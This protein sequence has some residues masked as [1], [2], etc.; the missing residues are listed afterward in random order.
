M[1]TNGTI[2]RAPQENGAAPGRVHPKFGLE[3]AALRVLE[4]NRVLRHHL[5][6]Y[7][8]VIQ[9]GLADYRAG[10]RIRDIVATMPPSDVTVG[11]QVEVLEVFEARRALRMALVAGLL[12]D[13][14]SVAELASTFNVSIASISNFANEVGGR[15]QT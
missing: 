3:S 1:I 8:S 7:D 6:A 14:M 15:D 2:V 5:D 12:D 10:R 13:G 4:A 9:G 11:S